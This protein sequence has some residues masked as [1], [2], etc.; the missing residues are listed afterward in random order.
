GNDDPVVPPDDVPIAPPVE[1]PKGGDR[2]ILVDPPIGPGGTTPEPK[3][4]YI[5]DVEVS[6]LYERVQ[7]YGSDGKLITES[8]KDYSRT[9]ITKEFA[10][11]DGFISRW[12][13]SDKK[14]ELIQAMA[15]Q[16][17]LI[18]ALREEV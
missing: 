7:Y 11:L 18:E 10:S 8:L 1:P 14:Q 6:V 3:K 13:A 4:Y 15:E 12:N 17:I 9:N 5:N 2:G 16:G